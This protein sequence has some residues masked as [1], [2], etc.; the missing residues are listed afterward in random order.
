MSV[1]RM[2]LTGAPLKRATADLFG[3]VPPGSVGSILRWP[4]GRLGET[5]ERVASSLD[6]RPIGEEATSGQSFCRP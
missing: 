4:P 2:S 5:G 6:A 3:L 1:S